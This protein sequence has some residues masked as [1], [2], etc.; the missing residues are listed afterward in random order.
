MRKE[1]APVTE[2]MT[3]ADGGVFAPAHVKLPGWA[4]C[5]TAAGSGV[6]ARVPSLTSGPAAGK[7]TGMPKGGVQ[8]QIQSLH[9]G[10]KP[11]PNPYIYKTRV[12]ALGGGAKGPHPARDPEPV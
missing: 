1:V 5:P 9:F 3:D 6:P 2:I 8:T 7:G 4:A 10:P 12:S 11:I